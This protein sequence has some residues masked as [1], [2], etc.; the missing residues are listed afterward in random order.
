[1]T[2][3]KSTQHCLTVPF[4]NCVYMDSPVR[5]CSHQSNTAILSDMITISL[6]WRQLGWNAFNLGHFNKSAEM[7]MFVSAYLC[8][9]A[10]FIR[11]WRLPLCAQSVQQS[12]MTLGCAF[13]Q[14]WI[15]CSTAQW[16]DVEKGGCPFGPVTL[17]QY[18]LFLCHPRRQSDL[19]LGKRRERP[20]GDAR[21]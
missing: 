10:H 8:I 4:P 18:E 11:I 15:S 7:I 16:D 17:H 20:S 21:W 6:W 19:R 5:P 9:W 12:T 14:S 3:V 2:S 1:M 13:L